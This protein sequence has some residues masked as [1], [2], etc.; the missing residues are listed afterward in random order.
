MDRILAFLADAVAHAGER[1]MYPV[2]AGERIYVLYLVSA[3]I[4]AYFVYRLRHRSLAPAQA[5]KRFAAYCFPKRVYTH[6]SA[7]IDYVFFLI[8]GVLFPLFAAPFVL[9]GVGIALVTAGALE[10]LFGPLETP[11]AQNW[12]VT[13]AATFAIAVAMDLGVFIAH[14]MQHRVPFLWEFHKV[15][16][17]AEVLTP[18]TVYRMHP[19][20]DLLAGSVSGMLTGVVGGLFAYLCAAQATVIALGGLNLLV[21]AFYV[22]GYNLRHSHIW[23]AYPRGLSHVLISPAQHQIH[24]SRLRHHH[25]RNFG[26]MFAFWDWAAGTLYV[27]ER[28]EALEYGID[29]DDRDAFRSVWALYLHPFARVAAMIRRRGA[30]AFGDARP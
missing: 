18:I 11:L 3:L 27:P 25:D 19:A 16:H 15:H 21:F 20:D 23:L 5:L 10:N 28:E 12:P 7:K 26:F 29:S 24:H 22:L 13:I 1:I 4:I 6:P 9:G 8:N 14:Y 30:A 2:A 17:S